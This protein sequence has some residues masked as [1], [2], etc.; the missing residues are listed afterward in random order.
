MT[1]PQ[2]QLV[3]VLDDD[4][5][6]GAALARLLRREGYRCEAF[7]DAAGLLAAHEADPAACVLTDIML[8]DTHGF[9]FADDLRSRDPLA[10]VIFMT[11]WPKTAAAVA[12][13]RRHGGIDYL[14][15]PIV[16]QALLASMDEGV[17]WSVRKRAAAARLE[18]LT[19]R[20]HEV[21]ALLTL[22]LSNKAIA[23]RLEISP[24]TVED[25]RAKIAQKTGAST[26]AQ[27]IA[28]RDG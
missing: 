5:D 22:G 3:Y 2:Q 6:L 7:I 9:T 18:A 25:H 27:L 17:T 19:A 14:E 16:E 13:V 8:G 1:Q 12:A 21:F 20:E 10:A 4:A 15:K 23:A 28:L 26:I 11:A 24:R